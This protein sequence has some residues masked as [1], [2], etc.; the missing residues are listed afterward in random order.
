MPGAPPSTLQVRPTGSSQGNSAPPT[1]GGVFGSSPP[2]YPGFNLQALLQ[3]GVAA[4]PFGFPTTPNPY[5]GY[6]NAPSYL[7]PQLN[8]PGISTLT[9]QMPN[10]LPT[11]TPGLPSLSP[12]GQT[13]TGTIPSNPPGANTL[14]GS[15]Q[16]LS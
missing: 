12:T 15:Q 13:P 5:S 10:T 3:N 8:A 9:G 4:T 14:L 7:G 11:N 16:A 2:P 6:M 1:G